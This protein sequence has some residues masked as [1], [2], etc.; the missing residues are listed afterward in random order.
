MIAY[1]S[2]FLADPL[3]Y[4]GYL[5]AFGGAMGFIIFLRG[6]LSGFGHSLRQDGNV[7]HMDHYRTRAAWGVLIMAYTFAL[8]EFLRWALSWFGYGA[9]N[10]VV[11]FAAVLGIIFTLWKLFLAKPAAGGH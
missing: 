1:L 10:G 4:S 8:W 9:V 5:F 11:V 2:N 3:Y 6:F 7:E